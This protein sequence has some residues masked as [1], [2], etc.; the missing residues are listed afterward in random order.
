[1]SDWP[2]CLTDCQKDFH[3]LVTFVFRKRR[4]R[5]LVRR[6]QYDLTDAVTVNE[7][8]TGVDWSFK[9]KP[10]ETMFMHILRKAATVTVARK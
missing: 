3:D 7:A 9:V 6:G 10:G 8:F 2:S 5:E 4:G 1:M